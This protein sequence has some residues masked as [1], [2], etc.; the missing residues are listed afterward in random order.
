MIKSEMECTELLL[1]A[2]FRCVV[3]LSS[4]WKNVGIT[5]TCNEIGVM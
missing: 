1:V 3:L 5:M 4:V 2:L